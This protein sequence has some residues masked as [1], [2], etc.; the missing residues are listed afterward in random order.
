MGPYSKESF[1]WC[2][3]DCGVGERRGWKVGGIVRLQAELE[4]KGKP[5][6]WV[7]KC[8]GHAE[9]AGGVPL[10]II[11]PLFPYNYSKDQP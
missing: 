2:H 6:R 11:F 3:G 4:E 5:V 1:M 8:D 9:R 7:G 10:Y